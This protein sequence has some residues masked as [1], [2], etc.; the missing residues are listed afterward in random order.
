MPT[1][2]KFQPV[3]PQAVAEDATVRLHYGKL[4]P[5]TFTSI[6]H[7]EAAARSLMEA[8]R[9]AA[10]QKSYMA[11]ESEG[12]AGTESRQADNH[13]VPLEQRPLV[14]DVG[15]GLAAG[16]EA[17]TVRG[18]PLTFE[19][20]RREFTDALAVLQSKVESQEAEILAMKTERE[21]TAQRVRDEAEAMGPPSVPPLSTAAKIGQDPKTQAEVKVADVTP[22]GPRSVLDPAAEGVT[23]P[24]DVP[25]PSAPGEAPPEP[26][27]GEAVQPSSYD[28]SPTVEKV[29]AKDT[30]MAE[31][32]RLATRYQIEGRSKLTATQLANRVNKA[33]GL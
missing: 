15:G 14:T 29:S 4:K 13:L 25:Q 2:E 21:E 9:I 5:L 16:D 24:G 18:E 19:D 27:P 12:V 3:V 22:P 6:D 33:R 28:E 11:R 30:S 10:E 31:L 32:R 8:A 20:M 23:Q 26:N 17:S 1:K 7:A